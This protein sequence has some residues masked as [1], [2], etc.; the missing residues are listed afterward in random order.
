[1]FEYFLNQY[2]IDV[3]TVIIY[4]FI[5]TFAMHITPYPLYEMV[6]KSSMT[7][8]FWEDVNRICDDIL[9]TDGNFATYWDLEKK[10]PFMKG[11]KEFTGD[12]IRVPLHNRNTVRTLVKPHYHVLLFI[13]D[14][15]Y[16]NRDGHNPDRLSIK[17]WYYTRSLT[18]YRGVPIGRGA[19]NMGVEVNTYKSATLDLE[20]AMRFTQPGWAGRA[21]RDTS[22]RNGWVLVGSIKPCDIHIYSHEG[23]EHEC[24][25]AGEFTFDRALTVQNGEIQHS[26][27]EAV[28][29]VLAHVDGM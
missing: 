19:L 10:Y 9:R 7:P 22:Q 6:T 17:D 4:N 15:K 20:L 8:E 3:P 23:K 28:D 14:W 27:V 16:L 25:L 12:K 2:R 1:M 26:E 24:V 11:A 21:W 29:D 13:M 18:L 5:L